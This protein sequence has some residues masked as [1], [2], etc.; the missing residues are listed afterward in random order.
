MKRR[1]LVILLAAVTFFGMEAYAGG[2]TENSASAKPT[3][4]GCVTFGKDHPFG[5]TANKFAELV[6]TY[7]K[8]DVDI[9]LH[10]NAELGSETDVFGYMS[11]GTSVD[12]AIITP[13]VITRWVPSA[14]LLSAPFVFKDVENWKKAIKS[15]A[16]DKIKNEIESKGVKVFGW[17]GGSLRNLI[18]KNYMDEKTNIS[19]LKLRVQKSP[20]QQ[21]VFMAIGFK[22]VP[23]EY[24]EVYDAL[25]T[26]VIDG[27]ENEPAGYRDMKFYEVAP[28]F[29]LS[30]HTVALWGFMFGKKALDRLPPDLQ[31][32][33]AKAG[34]EAADYHTSLELAKYNSII[35][36]LAQKHKVNVVKFDN[37][38]MR[39]KALPVIKEFAK[40]LGVSDV[41]DAINAIK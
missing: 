5:M 21:N 9:Q 25:R 39:S 29:V 4:V 2:K 40:E 36:E 11:A 12:F 10:Y 41:L 8:G 27:L 35:E 1:I 26:G 16:L 34:S 13:A 23:I 37:S 7:Y 19:N 33:I 14:A 15:N 3:I 22:P 20:L 31:K 38:E 24:Q 32:A 30:E 6:H 17:E 28:Y 18:L